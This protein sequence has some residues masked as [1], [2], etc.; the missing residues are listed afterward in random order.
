MRPKYK[1]AYQILMEYWNYLSMED[2]IEIDKRL[3][4]IGL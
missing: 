1:E 2:R 3:K 4:E